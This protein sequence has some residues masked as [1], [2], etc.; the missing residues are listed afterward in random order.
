MAR[1]SAALGGSMKAD[2]V[3]V[4][5]LLHFYREMLRIRCFEE[6]AI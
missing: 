2:V 4:E 6:A 3:G 5:R 1:E